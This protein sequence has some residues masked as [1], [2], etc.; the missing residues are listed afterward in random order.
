MRKINIAILSIL[1]TLVAAIYISNIIMFNNTAHLFDEIASNNKDIQKDK[2]NIVSIIEE[3][4][5]QKIKITI[6]QLWNPT[7][8]NHESQFT[9][10]NPNVYIEEY[11]QTHYLY[12]YGKLMENKKTTNPAGAGEGY[13]TWF[14]DKSL[15]PAIIKIEIT[16][17]FAEEGNEH[18][19]DFK[20]T[21]KQPL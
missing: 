17:V 10:N 7:L 16:C 1:V 20:I 21:E 13:V 8:I 14:N 6:Y 4:D 9:Y 11:S 2:G 5:E 3:Q 12:V 18:N 15:I 19:L